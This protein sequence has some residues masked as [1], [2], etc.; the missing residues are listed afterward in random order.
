MGNFNGKVFGEEIMVKHVA[1]IMDGNRRW[2][3]KRGLPIVFGHRK[4]YKRIEEIVKHA[5]SLGIK[6]ITFWAFSTENWNREQKEIDDLMNI[7]RRLFRD[8]TIKNIIKENSRIIIFGNLKKFPIDIQKGV[9]GVMKD[10]KKN[11]GITVNIALNYGGRDEI[12]RAVN[13]LLK[14]K[15]KSINEETFSSY[16][17]SRGQPDPDMIIRTGGEQRLSGYLPWQSVYSEL[18]FTKM[19]WPDFDKEEFD[20]AL[21]DFSKR[22]RRF[23]S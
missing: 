12:I 18:Y 20:K 10:T 3:R 7:F 5:K 9:K 19:Y 1:I 21:E 4:G 13:T 22:H 2:A 17:Y 16:L 6:H 14:E 11:N 15:Q 8:S 23:G